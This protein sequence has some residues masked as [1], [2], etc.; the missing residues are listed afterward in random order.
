MKKYHGPI[1][2]LIFLC[3]L[4]LAAEGIARL[5][6]RNPTQLERILAILEQDPVLVWKQRP[7]MN[8]VFEGA[9]VRTNSMGLRAGGIYPQRQDNTLRIVCLG[10]SPTFG[11]GV[12]EQDTYPAQLQQLIQASTS[13]QQNIE[14]IN[15]GVIGYSSHQGL[16][17]LKKNILKLSPDIITVAYGINDVDKYRFFRS[18]GE[19]DKD[20]KPRDRFTILIENLL[21]RS[22]LVRSL[23]ALLSHFQ[24]MPSKYFGTTGTDNYTETLRVSPSEYR[25]NLEAIFQL[26]THKSIKVVFLK[27]PVGLPP[28]GELSQLDRTRLEE[29]VTEAIRLGETQNFEEAIHKLNTVVAHDPPL[30]KPYYL[31]GKY[32]SRIGQHEQARKNYRLALKMEALDCGMRIAEY[33]QI[34]E[35][36][37][38][39]NN[40]L[41][42]DIVSAFAKFSGSSNEELF[43]SIKNDMI[44][45]SKMGH[46]IIARELYRSLADHDALLGNI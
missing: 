10:A 21:G 8:T 7:N 16:S 20:L 5:L 6:L 41:L 34:T 40:A 36:V 24:V 11:W 14:V 1:A 18:T 39:K 4:F 23:Q 31:L 43:L 29:K 44:H 27:I 38:T 12:A 2:G 13:N 42:V 32:Y 35:S 25:K 28:Q 33:N 45:P 46:E 19:P 22:Y 9:L 26:A 30:S 37:A 17:L 3:L 15:A